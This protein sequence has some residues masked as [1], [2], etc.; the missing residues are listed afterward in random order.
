LRGTEV[1]LVRK[2]D[3][4]LDL[5]KS[6]ERLFVARCNESTLFADPDAVNNVFP[7]VPT[8]DYPVH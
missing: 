7:K 4:F 2:R 3:F 6:D 1:R 8:P 5:E